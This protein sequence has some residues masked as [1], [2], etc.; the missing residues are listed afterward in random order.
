MLVWHGE[1]NKFIGEPI[2]LR[3]DEKTEQVCIGIKN[4]QILPKK[5][6]FPNENTKNDNLLLAFA[7][8]GIAAVGLADVTFVFVDG[9]EIVILCG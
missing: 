3:V 1:V 7:P 2:G 8:Q 9:D 6:F 4:G 5:C